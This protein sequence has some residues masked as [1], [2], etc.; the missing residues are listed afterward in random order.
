M[1]I[2]LCVKNSKTFYNYEARWKIRGNLG[3]RIN[4]LK[5]KT[6]FNKVV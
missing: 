5:L 4:D 3:I 6:T 2:V 1:H